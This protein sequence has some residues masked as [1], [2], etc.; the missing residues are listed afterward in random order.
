MFKRLC[1]V[2][3]VLCA[4]ATSA[5]AAPVTTVYSRTAGGTLLTFTP[6]TVSRI[7]TPVL[8]FTVG[9]TTYS[10]GV[11]DALMPAGHTAAAFRA[12][13]PSGV[14]SGSSQ[15]IGVGTD[16]TPRPGA[17]PPLASFLT[18]GTRG[19]ELATA[20]FNSP[21]Q[22]L[23]FPVA[24]SAGAL[25]S[26]APT[27]LATQMGE[28]NLQ[29]VYRFVNSAGNTVGTQVALTYPSGGIGRIHWTFLNAAGGTSSQGPGDRSIR[30]AAFTLG[31]FG[32]NAANIGDVVAFRQQLSGQ[33]DVAFVAY[34]EAALAVAA[35]D[36]SIDLA[37]LPAP[38]L[39]APYTG[40]FTCQNLGPSDANASTSCAVSNLPNGLSAG[41]CTI[42]TTPTASWT[43]GA[44]VPA[45]R[46]V[47][48]QVTGAPNTANQS[49][50]VQGTTSGARVTRVGGRDITEV[51]PRQD[52]NTATLPMT[53]QPPLADMQVS[54]VTL[55]A[56]T[57]GVAYTG[58]F[59]CRN[60][61]GRP[62]TA[63]TCS[64][65]GLPGW[66]SVSCSPT[67]PV[68]SLADGASITCT[69]S[70]TPNND[71][72]TFPITLHTGAAQ[73]SNTTNNTAT[74]DLAVTGV[75]NVVVSLAR[76]PAAGTV[77]QPYSGQFTCANIGTADAPNSACGA[78]LAPWMTQGACT[79]SPAG[80]AWMSPAT[81]PEGQTV[82][83]P[84]TGTPAQPGQ[85]PVT[86][87]GG[88][89]TATQNVTV[90]TPTAVPTLSQWGQVLM[91]GLLAALA[92]IVLRRRI[93]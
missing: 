83:C 65:T 84:V 17:N 71:K 42:D 59:S 29:E 31:E 26:T 78:T 39:N 22:N 91:A 73:E 43:A 36:M 62:A 89:S 69:V 5:T 2:P 81:I 45:G 75:P 50:T 15:L 70:G 28:N 14:T 54:S 12:F 13:T 41:A 80:A 1:W 49:V 60:E 10:T 27:I 32:L 34:N 66:A 92:G 61:G 38:V 79:I 47:T 35:P 6:S 74:A 24:F 20:L 63:A 9:T 3:A 88:A 53:V 93:G 52:N 57:V 30:M 76:L 64:A 33:S 48:C 56:A 58:S 68:D 16:I 72:G 4:L 25:S 7:N 86:V 11:D 55:P 40:Q 77:G 46:T 18:D 51:D 85:W 37:G 82:T 90:A 8:G 19:L 87:S 21:V 67:P 23:D 44:A